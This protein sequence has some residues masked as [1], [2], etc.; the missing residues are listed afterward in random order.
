MKRKQ[1][2]QR[3]EEKW[4]NHEK[5]KWMEFYWNK[6]Y[7]FTFEFDFSLQQLS[8]EL[9]THAITL[10]WNDQKQSNWIKNSR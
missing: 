3:D 6:I 8:D 9:D 4:L 10:K 5:I 7:N 2:A 1:Q